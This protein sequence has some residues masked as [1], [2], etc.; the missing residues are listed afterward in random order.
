MDDANYD[1]WSPTLLPSSTIQEAVAF[2]HTHLGLLTQRK[3]SPALFSEL[4]VRLQ[5]LALSDET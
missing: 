3:G 2:K 4:V 5:M 1:F